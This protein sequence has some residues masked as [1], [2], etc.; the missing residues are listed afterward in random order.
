MNRCGKGENQSMT[1]NRREVLATMGATIAAGVVGRARGQTLYTA[2]VV[3]T[4]GGQIKGTVIQGVSGYLGIPYGAP[5]VGA[6][7][8]KPPQKRPPWRGVRDGAYYGYR[9]IQTVGGAIPEGLT[10]PPPATTRPPSLT[11]IPASWA[12]PASNV[13]Q[14]E[15][16]LYLD[17]WTANPGGTA[18]K[19]VIVWLHGGGFA[20]G[21]GSDPVYCGVN[22]VNRGDVVLVNITHRLNVFGYLHLDELLG[23][24]YAGSGNAGILDLVAALEWVRDN[25]GEFGGDP[26]NVTIAGESGG[27]AK[28]S[29]VLAMPAA[30][31]LFHKAIV[32]SGSALSFQR[33]EQATELARAIAIE[34]GVEGRWDELV[35]LDA[36]KL[37][38][39]SVAA[40]R[41]A[42]TTGRRPGARQGLVPVVDGH[43]LPRD[44]FTPDAPTISANVPL[45]VGTTKDEAA[46]A[47]GY[48]PKLFE[49]SEEDMRKSVV[50]MTG[51]RV[52]EALAIYHKL[53]PNQAPVYTY[54]DASTGANAR[55]NAYE[56]ADRKAAQDEAPVWVY[57]VT[58]QEAGAKAKF[59][60][61]HAIDVGPSFANAALT[62]SPESLDAARPFESI[63]AKTWATF[64]HNGNPNNPL[65]PRWPAYDLQRRP[66]MLISSTGK[67]VN[68]YEGEARA[69]WQRVN[70]TPA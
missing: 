25:I 57:M 50:A 43:F 44:P 8:F 63:M 17:V 55:Y 11:Q 19:P 45:L 62:V 24:E 36:R 12:D 48:N 1:A 3:S 40:Q 23:E 33:P 69:F 37:F 28:V 61:R 21:A 68:D 66:T 22:F 5:P 32:M 64:A 39:A 2:A 9:S 35:S 18:K 67:V 29:A 60:S 49:M 51:D 6:L 10:L 58:W 4:T 47:L 26:G 52:D 42:A 15:D 70:A 20:G 14:S 27:G 38:D 16:C 31:G 56:M 53:R 65:L 34:A 41:Q 7:R 54:V 46:L 30:S 13:P 59:R